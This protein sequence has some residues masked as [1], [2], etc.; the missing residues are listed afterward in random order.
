MLHQNS[1]KIN[2]GKDFISMP[3]YHFRVFIYLLILV[4]LELRCCEWAF[5][6]CG[7]RG[8]LSNCGEWASHCSGSSCCGEQ[9]LEARELQ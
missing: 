5:S 1:G 7:K 2:H 9:P 8:L 6:S 3:I 4:A